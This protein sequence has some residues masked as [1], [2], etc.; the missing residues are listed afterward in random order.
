MGTCLSAG[1]SWFVERPPILSCVKR[2]EALGM[3]M[4]AQYTTHLAGSLG[5]AVLEVFERGRH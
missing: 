1:M 3:K 5:G 2:A 4:P